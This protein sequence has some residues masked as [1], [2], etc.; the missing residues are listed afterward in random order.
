VFF[1]EIFNIWTVIIV[2]VICHYAFEFKKLETNPKKL[3][4]LEQRI[5]VLEKKP[6]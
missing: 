6:E 1:L 2:A 4:E 5:A 3:V